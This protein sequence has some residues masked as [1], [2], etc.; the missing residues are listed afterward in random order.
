V[1]WYTL[2]LLIR[3]RAAGDGAIAHVDMETL[4]D[5]RKVIA[6]TP[7]S[8]CGRVVK[9][10]FG[11]EVLRIRNAAAAERD[12]AHMDDTLFIGNLGCA[13]EVD[14]RSALAQLGPSDVVVSVFFRVSVR[15]SRLTPR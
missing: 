11:R 13:T 10:D 4:P 1:P 9:L 3:L 2:R 14:V 8:I 15:S 12:A 6:H 7:L 5:A